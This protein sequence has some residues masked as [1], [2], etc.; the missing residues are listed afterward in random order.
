MQKTMTE[1]NAAITIDTPSD[2]VVGGGV[3]GVV[4][5]IVVGA[6]VGTEVTGTV[7][8]VGVA[9]TRLKFVELV[10]DTVIPVTRTI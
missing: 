8:S 5:G 6:E 3:V 4:D 9:A 7:V 1:N 2:V 10:T